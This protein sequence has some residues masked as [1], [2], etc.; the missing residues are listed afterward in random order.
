[1]DVGNGTYPMLANHENHEGICNQLSKDVMG[2]LKYF[3]NG[4]SLLDLIYK[5]VHTERYR[6]VANWTS[7]FCMHSDWVM[8]YFVNFYNAT[9]HAE[10]EFYKDVPQERLKSYPNSVIYDRPLGMCKNYETNCQSGSDICHKPQ[11]EWME[12]ESMH[13]RSSNVTTSNASEI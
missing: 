12:K 5:Y 6:D 9:T 10:E 13:W 2:E 7:G 11:I 1:M 8:G 3:Q 4:M